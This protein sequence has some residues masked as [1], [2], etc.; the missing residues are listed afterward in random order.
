MLDQ[1]KRMAV[2]ATVVEQGSFAGG[3]PA[4]EDHHLGRQPAGAGAGARHGRDPAA[5][6][7]PQAEPD[8]GRRA[9]PRRLR[10]HAG[11]RAARPSCSSC[12]CATRLRA[13]CAWPRPVGFAR[14]L[15]PALAPLLAANPGLRLHLEVDDGF[16]D[17][18]AK[19]I[20]LAIRFGRLPDSPWV[21]QRIGEKQSW[22]SMPRRPIWPATACPP[23]W[24]A[25]PSTTGWSC[26]AEYRWRA[27]PAGPAPTRPG[28]AVSQKLRISPRQQ[29]QP[30]EPAAALRSR[31]GP[32]HAQPGAMCARGRA[33]R[34]PAATDA[35]AVQL[36]SPAHLGPQRRSATPSRPRCGMPSRP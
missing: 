17:L 33:G 5:P 25:W 26:A 10:R 30:V 9:F 6:L 16:T 35:R 13:S 27:A 32:G 34:P 7:H 31:P 3:R 23:R 11:R 24:R 2:L 21:A 15:G 18:L 1:L 29:Q 14:H 19:R 22:R 4:A 12:S 28:A 20:D 36:A 8:A